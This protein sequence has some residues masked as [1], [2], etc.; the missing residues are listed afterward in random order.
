[1]NDSCHADLQFTKFIQLIFGK[2]NRTGSGEL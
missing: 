2:W 1:M